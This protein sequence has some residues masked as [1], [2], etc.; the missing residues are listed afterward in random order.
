MSPSTPFRRTDQHEAAFKEMKAAM[1][2]TDE[3]QFHVHTDATGYQLGAV[4]SQ[5]GRPLVF[6][7]KK[8]NDAHKKYPANKLE[9]LNIML[10][11]REYPTMLLGHIHTD[12][13][14]LTYATYKKYT[15]SD[16]DSRLKSLVPNS[17]M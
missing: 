3:K 16:G 2:Q 17:I 9:L 15:C 12:H 13:L 8:C 14:N 1:M 11:L 6:W 5:A 4:I 10:V 7:S